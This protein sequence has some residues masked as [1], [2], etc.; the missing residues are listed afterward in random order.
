MTDKDKSAETAARHGILRDVKSTLGELF[1]ARPTPQQQLQ[2][3]VLFGLLGYLARADRLVSTEEASYTNRLMDD[4]DL[5]TAARKRATEAFTRGCRQEIDVDAEVRRF[6]E[7]HAPDSPETTRLYECLLRLAAA[8][9]RIHPKERDLLRKI[10]TQLGFSVTNLDE[11]LQ[12]M[13]YVI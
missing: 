3:E 13:L 5:V 8:D 10:G 9:L 12:K 7:F 6:L 2:V 11:R 4:L 1:G